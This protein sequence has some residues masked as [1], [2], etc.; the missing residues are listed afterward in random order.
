MAITTIP[1]GDGSG[2]NIYV[3]APSQTGTQT[4]SVSSDANT[5]AARTKTVTFTASGVSPVTLTVNQ[6]A[7]G[8]G[9]DISDYVQDG[10]VLHLDGKNKGETS[11]RWESLVGTSYYTLNTHSTVETNAVVMDG[12]GTINGTNITAVNFEAG[13]IEACFETIDGSTGI[14]IFASSTGLGLIPRP[15]AYTFGVAVGNSAKSQW[16][17]GSDIPTLSTV[18]ASKD[19]LKVN[20]VTITGTKVNNNFGNSNTQHSIGGRNAGTNRYYMKVRIFSIR[21][22]NRLLTEEEMLKN[23]RVDNKRFNLGLTI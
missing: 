19:R 18:S 1:W 16:P 17:Y 20:G 2:D 13:T 5:G 22:Y 15:Q 4:V 9:G 21:K 23:Q 8:G 11:G 12:A 7:G 6:A 14:L 10:L 3:S